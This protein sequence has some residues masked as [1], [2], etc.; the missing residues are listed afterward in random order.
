MAAPGG[1]TFFNAFPANL[2]TAYPVTPKM[3]NARFNDPEAIV[4]VEPA[5]T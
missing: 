1:V 4:P 2:M 5:I 3:N